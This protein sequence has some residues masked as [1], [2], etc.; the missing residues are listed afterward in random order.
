MMC[1]PWLITQ[2]HQMSAKSSMCTR[3]APCIINL[4]TAL[5]VFPSVQKINPFY[6][7][8][9]GDVST[10]V[11]TRLGRGT[12]YLSACVCLVWNRSIT[13]QQL[14]MS[15][16]WF[17]KS[18]CTV[19]ANFSYYL[20]CQH[21]AIHAT[22]HWWGHAFFIRLYMDFNEQGWWGILPRHCGRPSPLPLSSSQPVSQPLQGLSTSVSR[23]IPKYQSPQSLCIFSWDN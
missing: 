15:Q 5:C 10:R 21:Q 18:T 17:A 3:C 1:P 2:R 16:I 7:F 22:C 12:F 9:D 6:T 20:D 23:S 19:G 4:W 8:I 11:Q 14:K 13:V